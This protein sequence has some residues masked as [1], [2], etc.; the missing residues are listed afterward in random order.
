MLP[1]TRDRSSPDE[2]QHQPPIWWLSSLCPSRSF[3][4]CLP[5]LLS[6]ANLVGWSP[7]EKAPQA[8]DAGRPSQSSLVGR[9][10]PSRCHPHP[11]LH[12]QPLLSLCLTLLQHTGVPFPGHL[13]H[14][15]PSPTL[16]LLPR[17]IFFVF[18][19]QSPFTPVI[20]CNY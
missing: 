16:L 5:E 15:P 20:R 8:P 10:G 7:A 18:P 2:P 3:S 17:L 1:E 6:D 11:P 13:H 14:P 12:L 19:E 4:T 9:I